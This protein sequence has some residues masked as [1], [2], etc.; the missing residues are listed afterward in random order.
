M[1]H[2]SNWATAITSVA[3][4]ICFTTSTTASAASDPETRAA[5]K[6]AQEE[7][8]QERKATRGKDTPTEPVNSPPNISGVPSESVVQGEQY[9]FFPIW[10]D[11]DNDILTFMISGRPAWAN[12]DSTTGGLS[13]TPTDAGTH[14][15]IRISVSD[16]NLTTSLP[17]FTITV[18]PL[19]NRAPVITGNPST[20]ADANSA[21]TFTPAASDPDGD[22]LVFMVSGRP[23]WAS[24]SSSTGQLWGTPIDGDAR[25]Y[26]GIEIRVTDGAATTGLAPFAITVDA[27]ELPVPELPVPA[28]EGN[29]P[30]T[31]EQ[32]SPYA[33]TPA[34][35][36]TSGAPLTFSIEN[37]PTWATF[38][39]SDGALTGTP[40]IANIGV[41][42]DILIS[43]SNGDRSDS[44]P[45]FEITVTAT[46]GPSEV[47]ISN[48][49]P[50]NYQWGAL[51][52]GQIVYI[53]RDYTFTDI[54][55]GFGGLPYLR[56]AND[57]K[58]ST[59]VN[60]ISF[61][62]NVDV[63]VYVAYVAS[64]S[65][66]AAWLDS[67]VETGTQWN[68]T[69]R[70][71]NVY[72]KDFQAGTVVLGGNE[73]GYSMYSVAVVRQGGS[74]G[75]GNPPIG[76]DTP[77]VISGSPSNSI[78]PLLSYSFVPGATDADGSSLTFSIT[79]KP[80]WASFEPA[81]G[82]LTGTPQISDVGTDSGIVITVSDGTATDSLPAFS[83]DVIAGSGT[84]SLSW[85]APTRNEDG[86]VLEDL[87][88][89]RVHYGTALG[90]YPNTAIIDNPGL[91][92]YTIDNLPVGT[93]FFTVSAFD[94]NGNES[95]LSNI[96]S[97][98]ITN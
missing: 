17:T 21:Y 37:R 5:K 14:S 45:L 50:A 88:G 63:T 27:Q 96:D 6:A 64:I 38:D 66:P 33:F 20:Q 54:P 79:N 83:I 42:T 78:A 56:T 44:L 89:Y 36:D 3:A 52:Q 85:N 62:V 69:D 11:P 93:W 9:S 90:H 49:Q 87:A 7:S 25:T 70:A 16:G 59:S 51:A 74:G 30:T 68:T 12:F 41:T 97:I 95:I 4:I 71:L 29:P 47:E 72:A 34:V 24:F 40:T 32:D 77:P 31:V 57:D 84:A 26:S 58:F 18:A 19:P 53:D 22:D 80:A 98:T 60:A 61:D 65:T 76:G 46:D 1:T 82:T 15:D 75:P 91:T 35:T 81:T 92:T 94:D 10:D 23:A 13:G 67:W 43:V 48:T 86:S 55:D 8:Q 73:H 28:I 2:L 39:T